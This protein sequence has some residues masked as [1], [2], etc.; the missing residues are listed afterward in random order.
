MLLR[1]LMASLLCL[2]GLLS[3]LLWSPDLM[4]LRERDPVLCWV[5]L[6][7]FSL[8]LLAIG[9]LLWRQPYRLWHGSTY[10]YYLLT[11]ACLLFS[12][13]L[14]PPFLFATRPGPWVDR[15]SR[16]Q[17]LEEVWGIVAAG[18]VVFFVPLWLLFLYGWWP[19]RNRTP[20]I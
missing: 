15:A 16:M 7:V 18:I 4:L 2:F 8:P 19:A 13:V 12:S 11:I 3:V 1:R 6:G 20:S 10:L 5:P 17:S 9:I 14:V